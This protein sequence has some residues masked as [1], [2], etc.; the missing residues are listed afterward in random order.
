MK[1]DRLLL[2]L[3]GMRVTEF[4][5][6]AVSFEKV[7]SEDLESRDR[8]R[9]VGAGRKGIL[10]DVETKLFYI[11]FYLKVYPTYDL[12]GFIFTV[13]RSRC[14]HW[15]LRLMPL[16]EKT[17]GRHMVLPKRQMRSVEEFMSLCPDVKDLFIDGTERPVQ[18]SKKHKLQK[19]NYSGKKKTYTRKNTVVTNEKREILF[20]SPTKGGRIHDVKQLQKTGILHNL[21]P[22]KDLWVD[23]AYQGIEKII[24]STNKVMRP[25]QKPKGK[26]LSA[27]QKKE[28]KIISGIRIIVEHAINGVKRFGATSHIYRNRKG[29]DDRFILLCAGLWN[30]HLKPAY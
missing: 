3:T 29:Q 4:K 14:F 20:I 16:L 18:R 21:P 26:N 17:L 13:D 30:F 6:L 19:K 15:T 5:S 27:E 1:S 10:K 7:L 9:R 11:L 12:A 8:Q 23:K 25:H 28:N 22:D 24:S 2:A